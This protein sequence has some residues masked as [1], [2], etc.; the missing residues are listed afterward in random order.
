MPATPADMELWRAALDKDSEAFSTLF[1]RYYSL[2]FQY[3][4]KICS[5]TQTVEDCIQ[6]LFTEIWQRPPETAVQCLRAYLLQALKFKLY[7]A[8]RY[9]KKLS[10]LAANGTHVFELTAESFIA[11]Q[12]QERERLTV[13]INALNQLPPRQ[14]EIIYLKI[15]RGL[16]YEEVSLVMQI[17]YQGVR[18]LLYQALKKFKLLTGAATLLS[19]LFFSLVNGM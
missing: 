8:Y 2:L 14:K 12:E 3:G 1:R 5:N 7:K 6:E 18:N 13:L 11:A 19:M 4:C 15:Y 10:A 16:S 17:N 9:E